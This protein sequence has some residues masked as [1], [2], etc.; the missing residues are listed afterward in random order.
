MKFSFGDL[1]GQSLQDKPPIHPL[2]RQ[3][4]KRWVKLR[5]KR[6]FP[7]LRDDPHALERA[8][9]QLGLEAHEGAGKGGATVY[10]ITLPKS[11]QRV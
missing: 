5:L 9:Q 11:S 8:Y 3:M 10:E 2:E 7:E 6:L 4:A 1:L